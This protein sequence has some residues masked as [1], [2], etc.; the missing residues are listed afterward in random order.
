[1][2]FISIWTL[3]L[4]VRKKVWLLLGEKENNPIIGAGIRHTYYQ[5]KIP[6]PQFA[7]DL[8][9]CNIKV[10]LTPPQTKPTTLGG[11]KLY[12]PRTQ[13]ACVKPSPRLTPFH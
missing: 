4:L 13:A 6:Q 9:N 2:F 5:Y 7:V 3:R 8:Q 1:M 11:C 12:N 10:I